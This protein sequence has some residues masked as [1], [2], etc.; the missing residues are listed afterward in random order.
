MLV[1]LDIVLQLY[2]AIE[3]I[4]SNPILFAAILPTIAPLFI[5]VSTGDKKSVT[6]TSS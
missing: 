2:E 4:S 3:R 6:I 1:A 5:P